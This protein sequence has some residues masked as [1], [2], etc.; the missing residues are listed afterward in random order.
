MN[1]KNKTLII[2]TT[3]KGYII[4][5]TGKAISKPYFR[6]TNNMGLR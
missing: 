2:C 5:I 4:M 1:K 3:S 6:V